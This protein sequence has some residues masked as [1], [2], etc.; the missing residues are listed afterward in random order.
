MCQ[1]L[2]DE[3]SAATLPAHARA[4]AAAQPRRSIAFAAL[5]EG[6]HPVLV[7]GVAPYADAH[8]E[9]TV[10]AGRTTELMVVLVPPLMPTVPGSTGET[11][12]AVGANG[13]NAP[14][15]PGVQ[16][17][18]SDYAGVSSGTG[19]SSGGDG[20][21]GVAV[22]ALPNTGIGQPASNANLLLLMGGMFASIAIGVSC[23]RRR[24]S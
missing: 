4:F 7:T 13:P 24:R 3:V 19:R 1:S 22:R 6:V 15:V 9:V 5:P 23:F 2:G 12:G 14:D 18:T 10:M 20:T 17:K 16:T 8:G 11:P 21:G